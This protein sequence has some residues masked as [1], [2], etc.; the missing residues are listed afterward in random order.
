MKRKQTD[1]DHTLQVTSH[2]PEG[3][4]GHWEVKEEP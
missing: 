1:I 4:G 2:N 3:Q